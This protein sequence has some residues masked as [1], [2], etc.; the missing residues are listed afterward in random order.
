MTIISLDSIQFQIIPSKTPVNTSEREIVAISVR[1]NVIIL[2][3]FGLRIRPSSNARLSRTETMESASLHRRIALPLFPLLS[4]LPLSIS[5]ASV[6]FGRFQ[7][8]VPR[9]REG[10]RLGAI[11][12]LVVLWR[13][14]RDFA[15]ELRGHGVVYNGDVG[16][17]A[18]VAEPLGSGGCGGGLERGGG[19]ER[20]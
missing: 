15:V 6:R 14:L 2:G 10:I 4:L 11:F 17:E 1:I 16:G 20:K 12:V 8:L 13:R 9:R 5:S 18:G 7:N 19:C 3:N